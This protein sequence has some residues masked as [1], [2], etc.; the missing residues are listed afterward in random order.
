MF[1]RSKIV[2]HAGHLARLGDRAADVAMDRRLA[3][4]QRAAREDP[5]T[6]LGMR[7]GETCHER[8]GHDLVA[9]A[10]NARHAGG[11][12]QRQDLVARHVGKVQ[13]VHHVHVRVDQPGHGELAARVDP[14]GIGG[15]IDRP[16]RAR[17][18]TR[19]VRRG[20]RSFAPA[21]SCRTRD[22]ISRSLRCTARFRPRAMR[23]GW[24]ATTGPP[25]P[26]ESNV[27][28]VNPVQMSSK[29]PTPALTRFRIHRLMSM[30]IARAALGKQ[31]S[32]QMQSG[33]FSMAT[34]ASW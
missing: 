33:Q 8:F 2:E 30:R 6:R 7:R 11:Q 28:N 12:I 3:V 19:S 23:P 16:R 29:F 25:R 13:H 15:H 22:R 32:R 26:A 10:A 34:Q 27:K 4:Q 1:Q 24:P 17:P 21:A 20:P 18:P 31:I 9:G 5:R 14:H